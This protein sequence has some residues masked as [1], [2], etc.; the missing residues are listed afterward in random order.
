MWSMAYTL[1]LLEALKI[2]NVFLVS[3]LKKFFGDPS[4][5]PLELHTKLVHHGPVIQP[6]AIL[7]Q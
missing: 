5:K 7:G 3:L 6:L 2:H 4:N 1:Q